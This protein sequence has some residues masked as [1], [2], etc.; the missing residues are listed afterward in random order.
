MLRRYLPFLGGALALTLILGAVALQPVSAQSTKSGEMTTLERRGIGGGAED[1]YLAEALG[2]TVEELQTAYNNALS[3][4]LDQAVADGDLT[5]DEADAIEEKG[6]RGLYGPGS[7]DLDIDFNTYLASA[8]GITED[9]LKTAQETAREEARSAFES[10]GGTSGGGPGSQAN[11]E[12]MDARKAL[13]SNDTFKTTMQAAFSDAVKQAVTDG[14]ITQEQADLILENT[15]DYGSCL[16]GGVN[17]NMGA[18]AGST[19]TN[20][21]ASGTGS[22]GFPG[23]PGGPGSPGGPGGFGGPAS[24]TGSN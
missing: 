17:R 7:K 22:Q 13:Y 14:V 11:T 12:L 5:Q 16:P 6:V 8:L 23:G 1:E 10:Q 4:A 18:P 24:G 2:I 3:A 9:E 20:Q 21:S 15:S 19:T